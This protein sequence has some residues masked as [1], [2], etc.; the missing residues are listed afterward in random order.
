MIRS[1]MENRYHIV[2]RGAIAG[3][4]GPLIFAAVVV[5]L[6]VAEYDFLRGLGWHPIRRNEVAWPSSTALGPYGWLQVANFVI[7]GLLMLVFAA[8]LW[9]AAKARGW[10][11]VGPV[12]MFVAGVALLILG[13]FK[14]DRP[15]AES[16]SG[17]MHGGLHAFSPVDDARLLRLRLDLEA[18]SVLAG[19]ALVLTDLGGAPDR[20][21]LHR[22]RLPRAV[23]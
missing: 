9:R 5:I 19:P 7:F 20:A 16:F 14:T 8:G 18:R 13:F 21:T 15:G 12:L 11:R 1:G 4:A 3:I 22:G 6:T 2:R 23:G 10:S 17:T